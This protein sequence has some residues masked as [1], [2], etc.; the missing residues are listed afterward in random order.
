MYEQMELD[1]NTLSLE[2]SASSWPFSSGQPCRQPL[3]MEPKEAKT[4][5]WLDPKSH[6]RM[7][8]I[9]SRNEMKLWPCRVY[10][11]A[12]GFLTVNRSE[13]LAKFLDHYNTENGG[14][15]L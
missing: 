10:P 8:K 3:K 4:T 1:S 9:L 13:F 15:E 6:T 5:N 11:L 2:W 12:P 7:L 14:Q